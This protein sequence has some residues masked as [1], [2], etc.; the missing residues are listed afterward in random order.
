MV[1]SYQLH[2]QGMA[3]VGGSQAINLGY[4]MFDIGRHRFKMSRRKLQKPDKVF[5]CA[6][7]IAKAEFG[8]AQCSKACFLTRLRQQT[9]HV[10]EG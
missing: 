1:N 2:C 8:S 6:R 4:R 9:A 5:C 3:V 7:I 10:F